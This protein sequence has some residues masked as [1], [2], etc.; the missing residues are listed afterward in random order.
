VTDDRWKQLLPL[1]RLRE[2]V[3]QGEVSST[4]YDYVFGTLLQLA[5]RFNSEAWA[6]IPDPELRDLVHELTCQAFATAFARIEEY[7][8]ARMA[9]PG[10]IVWRGRAL[11]NGIVGN[12]IDHAVRDSTAAAICWLTRAITPYSW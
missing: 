7:D 1:L 10:W 5:R 2:T 4:Y 9:L 6:P 12:A 8:P 11:M 3:A